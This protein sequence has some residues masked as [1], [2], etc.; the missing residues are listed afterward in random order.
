MRR[1]F[2]KQLSLVAIAVAVIGSGQV[3]AQEGSLVG[4]ISGARNNV[5]G[6]AY[7]IG[8]FR[9]RFDPETAT[10]EWRARRGSLHNETTQFDLVFP[11]FRNLYYY[12]QSVTITEGTGR[13]SDLTGEA[14]IVGFINIRSRRYFGFIDGELTRNEPPPQPPA[15][16][17]AD[18][19]PTDGPPPGDPPS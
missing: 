16:P 6:Y 5:S 12:E 13:F 18:N 9:G 4:W 1:L 14:R 17:P 15:E 3:A 19:P 2:I 10:A 11:I 8:R 7:P